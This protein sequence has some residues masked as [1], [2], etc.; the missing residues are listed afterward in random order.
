MFDTIV[1][2]CYP[3]ECLAKLIPYIHT[4]RKEMRG[5]SIHPTGLSSTIVA[6]IMITFIELFSINHCLSLKTKLLQT[7][8]YFIIK[9]AHFERQS[10]KL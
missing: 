8:V 9:N 5:P 2:L 1:S 3:S 6:I 10:Y 7:Q 4:M